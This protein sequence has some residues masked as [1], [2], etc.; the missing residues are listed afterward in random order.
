MVFIVAKAKHW[1]M[2]K[3]HTDQLPHVDFI[4]LVFPEF[5]LDWLDASEWGA[6][7][8]DNAQ[9]WVADLQF[10]N[11]FH[12]LA[13]WVFIIHLMT[14]VRKNAI[15]EKIVVPWHFNIKYFL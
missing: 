11:Y 5:A 14:V 10:Q 15:G 12:V 2:H 1:R 8:A 6:G 3:S 9:L 13:F 7:V 4:Y